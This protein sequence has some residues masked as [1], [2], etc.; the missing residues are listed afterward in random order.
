MKSSTTIALV[1]LIALVLL[2]LAFVPVNSDINNTTIIATSTHPTIGG[3]RQSNGNRFL[4]TIQAPVSPTAS[5]IATVRSGYAPLKVHFTTQFTGSTPIEYAWDFTS[6]GVEDN[7]I[8]DSTFTYTMPGTY[9]VTLTVTNV[10]GSDSVVKEG[11]ITVFEAPAP[12]VTAFTSDKRSGSVPLTISFT[13]CSTGSTPKTYLWDFGD[14]AASTYQNPTHS[15]TVTGTYMVSLT[16]TNSLGTDVRTK[17]GYV[18]TEG[19][20][21]ESHAGIALTFDDNSI[22]EWYAIR[23]ILQQYNAHVTFFVC[24]FG[25]LDHDKIDKLKILKADGNE[26]AFHGLY[27][28]DAVTYLQNHTVQQY[29][30]YEIIP[31]INLMKD[32]GLE[33]LDFA[34]P[35]GSD[36]PAINGMIRYIT[37]KAQ[38]KS[39]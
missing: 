1:A 8:K 21:K 10:A 38:T 28:T 2:L 11:Y 4:D 35:D 16:T 5:F 24:R 6:D 20:P 31:G 7:Y 18:V 19:Q 12:P 33:P 9:N 36:V 15:Y 3:F 26:I 27:H 32:A 22:D 14:G 17:T 37:H 13:D 39:L 23:P 30:D 25:S 34:Y 29:L